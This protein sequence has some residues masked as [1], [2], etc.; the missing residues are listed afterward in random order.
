[1]ARVTIVGL[2][3]GTPDDLTIEARDILAQAPEIW[4]RTRRHRMVRHL[5]GERVRSFDRE[6]ERGRALADVYG[7]IAR[8]LLAM[9]RRRGEVILAVPGHPAMGERVTALLRSAC[10][11]EGTELRIVPGISFLDAVVSL[12]GIDPLERGLQIVDAHDL[13][14]R[15]GDNG[16]F[17]PFQDAR[18]PFRTS[19]DLL[20]AQFDSATVASGVKIALLE[21]FPAAH[22]VTLVD[23]QGRRDIPLMNID[24]CPIDHECTLYVPALTFPQGRSEFETLRGIVARLRGPGGCP[25]DQEQTALSL[26]RHLREEVVEVVD[27]IEDAPDAGDWTHVAEEIGDVMMN[28]LLEAQIAEEGGHFTLED[29]TRGIV[30]KL[31]RRHPHVFGDVRVSGTAEVLS[32]WERIKIAERKGAVRGRLGDA[33]S[34]ALPRL[35]ATQAVLARAMSFGFVWDSQEGLWAKLREEVDEVQA[36]TAAEREMETGDL[37]LMV[38]AVANV[39]EID[40]ERALDRSLAKF[41][42]RFQQMEALLGDGTM[43]LDAIPEHERLG[44]WRRAKEREVRP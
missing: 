30:D 22:P 33:P 25:W 13:S 32:N 28:L 14:R 16:R 15:I 18:L 39:F 9:A 1:M 31:I 40:A 11:Q 20:I 44:L 19:Q 6:Y 21:S 4:V 43:R 35:S 5:P 24:R 10:I 27:A 3:S 17:D 12:L 23:S 26:L 37:L 38:C 42:G 7:A 34:R 41:R 29:V 8:R 36:A 2:G